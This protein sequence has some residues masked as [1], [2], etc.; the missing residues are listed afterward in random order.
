GSITKVFT[1]TAIM[2][3]ADEGKINLDAKLSVYLPGVPEA[4]RQITLRHLLSHK[5]GLVQSVVW[6]VS[7]RELSGDEFI[8][9]AAKSRLR[10]TPGT[11]WSYSNIG[12]QLLGLVLERI[13]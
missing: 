7:A 10:F 1:A 4:W 9:A 13:S 3:L 2:M 8:A 6:G 5:S 11:G 12:Y